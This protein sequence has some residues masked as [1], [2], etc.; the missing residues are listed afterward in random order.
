MRDIVTSSAILE[1]FPVASFVID[2]EHTVTHWNRACEIL[3]GVLASAMVGTREQWRAFYPSQRMVMADLILGGAGAEQV[4]A[5]YHG[6]FR[7]SGI[8]PGTFEAEDFFPLMGEGGRWL[9]FTAA[10]LRDAGGAVIGAIETLQDVSER[11]RAEAA[12]KESEERFKTLSRTDP[13]TRLFNFR[14]FHEQL[15][16]ETER[17]E[18]YQRPLS[19]LVID[20][21]NF[22]EVNDCHGHIGGDRVLRH[23]GD[24]IQRW[25]RRADKGFRYGGD[26]FAVLMPE[27]AIEQAAE[28]GQRLMQ[29]LATWSGDAGPEAAIAR[30]TLS[31]GVAQYRDGE[32]ALDFF[33]RADAAAYQAKRSGRNCLV[34]G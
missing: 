26:E 12:L 15:A 14:D 24:L 28:A 9:Y 32:R 4:D 17:S 27:A 31:V 6:K 13:L 23:L 34:R 3:T 18:R 1:A 8:I 30:C 10:P 22:K 33:Q 20:V 21:D 19:L 11:H 25:K 5:L 29:A 2:A 16:Y 7:P